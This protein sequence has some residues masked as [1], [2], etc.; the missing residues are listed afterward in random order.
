[1]HEV[2]GALSSFLSLLSHLSLCPLPPVAVASAL[3]VFNAVESALAAATAA[4]PP[5]PPPSPPGAALAPQASASSVPGGGRVRGNGL[6]AMSEFEVNKA[7]AEGEALAALY[8]TA[9]PPMVVLPGARGVMIS[10]WCVRGVEG[11]GRR[12]SWAPPAGDC[13]HHRLRP[14]PFPPT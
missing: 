9:P 7:A 14:P 5:P 1:V 3:A 11:G 8:G 6:P 12:E 2:E 10:Q 4:P 13:T